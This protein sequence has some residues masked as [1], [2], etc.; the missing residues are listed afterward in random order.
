[1][2]LENQVGIVGILLKLRWPIEQL[3]VKK[4]I[5]KFVFNNEYEIKDRIVIGVNR[6]VTGRIFEISL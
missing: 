6:K 3:N 5:I 2:F 4:I 1:M